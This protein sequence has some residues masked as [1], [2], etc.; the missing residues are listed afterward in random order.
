[1]RTLLSLF[2]VA[3]LMVIL[4]C[5]PAI[6]AGTGIKVFMPPES[7]VTVEQLPLHYNG[8]FVVLNDGRLDGVYVVRVAVDNAGAIGWVNVTP[9]GFVLKP[10][11]LR[12]VDF[13]IDIDQGQ[14]DFGTYRFVFM[15]SL[16]PQNVEP[17]IDTFATYVSEVGRYNFTV[18]IIG[19]PGMPF[20]TN[21]FAGTPVTFSET[22]SRLNLVQFVNPESETRVATPIDRA[23]RIN[24]P[25]TAEVGQPANVSVSV[26]E[27][28]SSRDIEL[29]AI[30]PDG[31]F[32]PIRNEN[33]T[34]DRAG[35]WGVIA[36]I[37]DVVLLGKPVDVSEGGANLV[38]PDL[39]TILAAVSLLLLLAL[40]PI[41]IMGRGAG[42]ADPYGEVAYKA[43]V[44][45]KYV[46]QFDPL[47]LRRA[48]G[49]LGEEYD[50]LVARN[51][52][53]DRETA[54]AALEELE[55]LSS[56]ESLS[57]V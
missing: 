48:V 54:R 16:L 56:L 41:W 8:S 33:I 27:G 38:M 42:R 30:A 31:I 2:V 36:L 22:K 25:P 46:G 7:S 20:Q 4:L 10:G 12:Q 24:V 47:R 32:Y 39:G 23:I 35:R 19:A 26:F 3:V 55:T 51:V 44:I 28:L 11:E 14:A 9:S 43:S 15:P 17:Y 49:Q 50:N 57:N 21:G 29:M 40:V 18:D 34:F 5:T 1:M 45:M 53:G 52:R 37:G 6:S 13:S